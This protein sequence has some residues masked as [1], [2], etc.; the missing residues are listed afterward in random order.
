VA[1]GRHLDLARHRVDDPVQE[2]VLVGHVVVERHR[3][4]AEL[5]TELAHA[6]R[7]EPAL[8]GERDRRAQDP[9]PPEGDP[10]LRLWKGLRGHGLTS[11]RR[12][13]SLRRKL[14]LYVRGEA[15]VGHGTTSG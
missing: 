7:L 11:L 14:T 13:V 9:L 6:E 8:V 3:L 2:V 10:R 15:D 12:M 1:L 4:D 5:L